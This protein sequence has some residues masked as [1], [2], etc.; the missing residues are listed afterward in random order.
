VLSQPAQPRKLFGS[1][2]PYENSHQR[3]CEGSQPSNG[4]TRVDRRPCANIMFRPGSTQPLHLRPKFPW[5]P[6]CLYHINWPDL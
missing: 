5:T 2:Q 6:V 4:S 1:S 3:A